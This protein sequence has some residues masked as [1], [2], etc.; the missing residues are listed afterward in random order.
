MRMKFLHEKYSKHHTRN[1]YL[2]VMYVTIL[3]ASLHLMLSPVVFVLIVQ[4]NDFVIMTATHAIRSLLLQT[5][6]QNFGLMK[7]KFLR[8]KCYNH[9]EKNINLIA[10]L[11]IIYM[12]HHSTTLQIRVVLV[13]I[14]QNQSKDFVPTIVVLHVLITA[15]RHALNQNFGHRVT[16]L[17]LDK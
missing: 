10:I 14:V 15:S 9:Q 2:T 7:T 12:N 4:A 13:R 3:S 8:D 16:M 6:C 1:V 5:L 17:H 11:V